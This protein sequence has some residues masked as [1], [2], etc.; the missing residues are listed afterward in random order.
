MQK[1]QYITTESF[2][3]FAILYWL[4]KMKGTFKF[5]TAD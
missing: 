3:E 1:T 5:S 2:P 4:K